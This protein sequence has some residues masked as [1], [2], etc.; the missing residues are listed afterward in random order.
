[1]EIYSLLTITCSKSVIE[2][3]NQDVNN[4]KNSKNDVNDCCLMSSCQMT[5]L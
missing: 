5:S 3:Q 2:T 4:N 1:M